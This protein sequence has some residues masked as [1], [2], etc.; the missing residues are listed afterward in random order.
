[1]G[2]QSVRSR[3]YACRGLGA[4]GILPAEDRTLEPRE[5]AEGLRRLLPPGRVVDAPSELIA[6]STD[7]SFYSH[8][9]PRAPDVVVVAR[10]ASDVQKTVAFAAEH[11]VP[12]TP[13]GASSGQ[14]GG[15]IAV[16]GGVVIALNAMNRLLE[17]DAEN[18]QV[19]VEPGIIHARLNEALA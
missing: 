5:L 17:L 12:I 1:M 14:T 10:A 11:G 7:A 16:P 13:R 18:L 9:R 8:L 19:V 4:C 2:R 6:Y 15:S 3:P